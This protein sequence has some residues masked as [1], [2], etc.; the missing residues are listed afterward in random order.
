MTAPHHRSE[1]EASDGRGKHRYICAFWKINVVYA[2]YLPVN[3]VV[4]AWSTVVNALVNG[5][6]GGWRGTVRVKKGRLGERFP[7]ETRRH[8]RAASAAH[9]PKF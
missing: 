8:D 9:W 2:V 5:A 4:N 6:E 1:H 7:S 3:G